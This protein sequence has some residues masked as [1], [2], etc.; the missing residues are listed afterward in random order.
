VR[1]V[2]ITNAIGNIAARLSRIPDIS[3]AQDLRG[4]LATAHTTV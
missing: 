4:R 1:S 2:R 3:A